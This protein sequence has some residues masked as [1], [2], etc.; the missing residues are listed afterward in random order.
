M[1]KNI[2]AKRYSL[3]RSVNLPSFLEKAGTPWREVDFI[4]RARP[5][6]QL[7]KYDTL[8]QLNI[9]YDNEKKE[10]MFRP[11]KPFVQK[12][13]SGKKVRTVMTIDEPNV[14]KEV[15]AGPAPVTVI[16]EFYPECLYET[17]CC[18]NIV[19]QRYYTALS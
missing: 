5:T 2:L 18:N 16:R 10:V 11:R 7:R 17:M 4:Y 14:L 12:G 15:Q 6:V 8:Y 13:Y 3:R 1:D 19:C 9:T